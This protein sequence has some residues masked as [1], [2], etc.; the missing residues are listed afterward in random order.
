M[1]R[2][3]C[4][5]PK[6][7]TATCSRSGQLCTGQPLLSNAALWL[8]GMMQYLGVAYQAEAEQRLIGGGG[9]GRSG[10]GSD[11]AVVFEA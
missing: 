7:H 11:E 1:G 2:A 9:D 3:G 5:T 10:S 6:R 8:R 4:R